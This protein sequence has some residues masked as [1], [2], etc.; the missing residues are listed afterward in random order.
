MNDAA[1]FSGPQEPCQ[2]T[3]PYVQMMLLS[4]ALAPLNIVLHRSQSVV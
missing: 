3:C 2:S 1:R 4:D